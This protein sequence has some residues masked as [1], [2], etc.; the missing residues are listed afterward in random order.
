MNRSTIMLLVCLFVA[1]CSRRESTPDLFGGGDPKA[2]Y[3][4]GKAEA[5]GDVAAARSFSRRNG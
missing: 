4:N 2:A 5:Q 3:Q 1:D